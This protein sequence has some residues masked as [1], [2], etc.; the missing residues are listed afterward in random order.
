[1]SRIIDALKFCGEFE[2]ALHG[3]DETEEMDKSGIFKELMNYTAALDNVIKDNLENSRVFN[4]TSKTIQNKVL[5]DILLEWQKNI[6]TEIFM[7][8]FISL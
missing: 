5:D 7:V 8:E 2:L 6:E 4:G 3:H 1:M